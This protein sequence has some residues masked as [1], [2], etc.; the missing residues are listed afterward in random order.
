MRIED[1]DELDLPPGKDES[2]RRGKY[3]VGREYEVDGS[4]PLHVKAPLLRF[5]G[6]GCSGPLIVSG[7]ST[8]P[9]LQTP[10]LPG[11]K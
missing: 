5:Q 6:W 2:S 9:P 3:Q 4:Y 8:V 7:M 11:Y 1:A 10:L